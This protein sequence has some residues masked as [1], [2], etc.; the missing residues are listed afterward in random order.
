MVV[1]LVEDAQPHRKG[2]VIMKRILSVILI[3]CMLVSFSGCG[4]DVKN[5]PEIPKETN[6]RTLNDF[7]LSNFPTSDKFDKTVSVDENTNDL[8]VIL[9]CKG[10]CTVE[11]LNTYAKSLYD[12][13]KKDSNIYLYKINEKMELVLGKESTEFNDII[14]TNSLDDYSGQYVYTYND[15]Q[16][17]VFING[18]IKKAI[19]DINFVK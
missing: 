19:I 11:D 9:T 5:D 8:S 2:E 6:T 4:K 7:G 12:E 3:L 1:I 16:I 14:L 15:K 17:K 10:T 13:T 18:N